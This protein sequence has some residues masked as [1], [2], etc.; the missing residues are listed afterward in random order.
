MGGS[1]QTADTLPSARKRARIILS[2]LRSETAS[3]CPSVGTTYLLV[4]HHLVVWTR[5][6]CVMLDKRG[7]NFVLNC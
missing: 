5:L 6:M 3:P 7:W 2:I 1:P 4:G